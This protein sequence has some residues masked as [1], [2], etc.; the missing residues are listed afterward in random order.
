MVEFKDVLASRQTVFAY[1]QALSPHFVPET[2]PYRELEL[3]R[4]M[5]AIAPVLEGQKAKNLFLYGKTGTGKSSCTRYVIQKLDA[6]QKPSVKAL[7]MNCRV[8][9][10]RY[11]VLQKVIHHFHPDFA[12][13]GYSFAVLYEKLLDWVEEEARQLVVALDEIDMVKDLDNLVYTLTRAN[14]DLRS[15]SISLIGVSNKVDFKHRLDARSRSSLCEE[16]LVFQ[17]YNAEQLTG[18][19]KKRGAQA[20]KEGVLKES[21]VNLAAAIAASENGDARYALLLLL[22]AG[23][24]CDEKKKAD[25]LDVDVEASRKAAEEEKAFEVI[26]TLPEHQQLLLYGLATLAS[27]V[28]YKRLVEEDGDKLYFSGEVYERYAAT[29]KKLGKKP[30]TSR[31]YRE[32]L[33]ELD[34]LGLIN[35]VQSGKGVRGHTTLI[36]LSYEPERV[37]Q[38]IEQKVLGE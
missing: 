23:E 33:K 5:E 7:Y 10:S 11:K 15:G 35:T 13:T 2:L 3:R 12:K 36:R 26:G 9:D 20:F 34:N 1:K 29:V 16:E 14:D 31:W 28:T 27:D 32:Y 25:V 22:R 8:Y 21:A 30:R 38:V 4:M 24:L 19:L 18:I 37:K 6:E 17:P